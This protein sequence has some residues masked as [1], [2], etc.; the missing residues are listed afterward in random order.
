MPARYRA[1]HVGSLLRPPELLDARESFADG[2]LATE[3]LRV[4]EDR[5]ISEALRRQ[6]DLGLD[7]VTDGEMRRGSWLSEL[8][9]AVD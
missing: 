5:A 4:V 9:N 1:D 3:N 8:A 7:I 6:R 2:H